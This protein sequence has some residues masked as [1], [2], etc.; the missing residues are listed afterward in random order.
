MKSVTKVCTVLAVVTCAALVLGCSSGDGGGTASEGTPCANTLPL[1]F[2][3]GDSVNTNWTLVDGDNNTAAQD[4]LELGVTPGTTATTYGRYY[5]FTGGTAN[6]EVDTAFGSQ[7]LKATLRTDTADNES[8]TLLKFSNLDMSAVST[9]EGLSFVAS[10]GGPD[11]F[12]LTVILSGKDESGNDVA[13]EAKLRDGCNEENWSTGSVWD[14]IYFQD[15]AW[16]EY[17]IPY[18]CF[19]LDTAGYLNDALASGNSYIF[20]TITFKFRYDPRDSN[21]GSANTGYTVKLDNIKL[22][23]E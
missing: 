17:K 20:D 21:G 1:T 8:W 16:L 4:P 14:W 3:D 19:Y 13:F 5:A 15:S 7:L 6:T 18:T 2:E 10:W 12:G 11:N 22:Y 23:T 9:T